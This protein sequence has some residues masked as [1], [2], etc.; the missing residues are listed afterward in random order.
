MIFLVPVGVKIK[1]WL[2]VSTPLK[3]ISQDGNLPQIGM[4]IKTYLKPPPRKF[5][6]Q[7]L[8]QT[9]G[10]LIFVG[11]LRICRAPKGK[12]I[13]WKKPIQTIIF[14]RKSTTSGG[15]MCSR[16]WGWLLIA[17]CY[18]TPGQPSFSASRVFYRV[19]DEWF[20][21]NKKNLTF[22]IWM[23]IGNMIEYILL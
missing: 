6:R 1:N 12:P 16:T 2:V 18:G 19:C 13:V 15:N 17:P 5:P 20:F 10:T 9:L 14:Q 11:P 3:N 22:C 4:K 8:C 23:L 21:V 7:A